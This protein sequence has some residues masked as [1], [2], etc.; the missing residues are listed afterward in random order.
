MRPLTILH[1]EWSDG[2]GGQEIRI[3][4][5]ARG[6]AERGHRV[7]IVARPQCKILAKARDAGLGT[8][9]L[10]MRRAFDFAAIKKLRDIIR[11]EKADIVVT[12][13]SVDSWIG[14]FAAKRAG[15]RLIRTRHL[16]SEVPSHP[17]NI[18][19][20]LPDA[21]VTT[22][23]AVRRQLI[24]HSR[25]REDRVTSIPTGVDVDKFSPRPPDLAAKRALG[26]P[27]DCKVATMVAVLRK[28]KRHELFL[29]AA[30]MLTEEAKGF[31][32]LV[33]GDGPRREIIEQMIREK[34]LGES[35]KMS[36]HVEDV[37]PILSFSDVAV[38]SSGWGEGVPQAIAQALAMARPVVATDV[39]SIPELVKHEETGLLVT[40]ENVQ[41]LAAAMKRMLTDTELATRC[42]KHGRA[43]VVQNFSREKMINDTLGLYEQ[44]ITE[45]AQLC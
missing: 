13:S 9:E 44:L 37:R 4:D 19:Y 1:T 10:E 20:R 22:G 34:N 2:W 27:D 3:V 40:K 26:L 29:E 14:A 5:E 45:S 32:F 38:L 33:V 18:I 24:E 41:A 30:R 31:R 36:G 11:A 28:F 16:S 7:L 35:V 21:V 42:G 23:E 39:G 12:H 17:L 8:I 15:T 6:I 43:H 25:L